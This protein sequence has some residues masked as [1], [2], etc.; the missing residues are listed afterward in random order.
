MNKVV[1]GIIILLLLL[2]LLLNNTSSFSEIE[3][4][5]LENIKFPYTFKYETA[6]NYILES[7]STESK[8]EEH[9]AFI[10]LLKQEGLKMNPKT[11]VK[12]ERK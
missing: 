5:N 2:L 3:L 11:F 4:D 10:E 9:D 12:C 6:P 8:V 7:M 1:V